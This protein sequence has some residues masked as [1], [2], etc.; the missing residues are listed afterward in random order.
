MRDTVATVN[1]RGNR[2][3]AD[4]VEISDQGSNVQIFWQRL[5]AGLQCLTREQGGCGFDAVTVPVAFK[6]IEGSVHEREGG[7]MTAPEGRQSV[8]AEAGPEDAAELP[9][10]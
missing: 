8:W 5:L 2:C 9:V 3:G 1:Q 7:M 6:G 4:P 10:A